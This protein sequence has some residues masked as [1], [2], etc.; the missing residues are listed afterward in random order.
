MSED[1]KPAEQVKPVEK[2]KPAKKAGREKLVQMGMTPQRAKELG[3]DPF[4][5]GG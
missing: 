1:V 3:L 2:E 5:Y 4:P